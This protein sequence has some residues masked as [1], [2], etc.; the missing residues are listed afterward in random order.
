MARKGAFENNYDDYTVEVATNILNKTGDGISEI[1]SLKLDKFKQLKFQLLKS[2]MQKDIFYDG[3][4]YTGSAGMA[5]YYL[6]QGIRK[7]DNPEYLQTAA[8]YIDVQNLKGRRIS[9]LC[10]DAGPLA[11]ATIIAYKLGST[12][13]ETLPDYETLAQRLQALI[14]LLN[15][16][17]DEIL[18]GKSGYLYALLF[19]SKH[20][21]E[22]DIIPGSHFE[23][24]ISS[25]M[26]S[27]KEFA[28]HRSSESPLLWQW[29]D[30][31][32]FGAAHGMAGIL[33]ILLQARAY[34]NIMDIKCLVKPTINWL[35]SQRFT[36]GNF[37]SSV[38]SAS[39]DR[40]VQWC[41][42]APGFIALCT[43]A[44][45]VFEDDK[46]L[47][48]AQHSCEVIWERGLSTKGY[49]LCH[50]VSGNAYSFLQMYQITKEYAVPYFGNIAH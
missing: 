3:T 6:M 13:P 26:K 30:K 28:A 2:K 42:G 31:V 50:G 44:A 40:L 37:P 7:P 11:I 45:E 19:V 21:P 5:L 46:Y 39:G 15:D 29:H 41:H 22:E 33:Y 9:F 16:S 12:R 27:G 24:V 23:M 4:I 36:S 8:K 49:S 38:G 18:Y 34:I 43:L 20:I 47:K 25:I 1:F 14:S 17:P 35:L 32:Y 10:G 48:I